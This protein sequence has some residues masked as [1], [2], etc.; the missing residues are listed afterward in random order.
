MKNSKIDPNMENGDAIFG[1]FLG[2]IHGCIV[3]YEN[4]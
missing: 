2:E 3:E 1:G 4:V